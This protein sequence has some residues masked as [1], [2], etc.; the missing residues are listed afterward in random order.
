MGRYDGHWRGRYKLEGLV[1]LAFV[2]AHENRENVVMVTSY[3]TGGIF[4][5]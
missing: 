1:G 2:W 3:A 5:M 4:R